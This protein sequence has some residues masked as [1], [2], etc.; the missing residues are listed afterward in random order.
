LP[1]ALAVLHE[2]LG[3]S[4]GPGQKLTLLEDFDRVLGLDF[5]DHAEQLSRVSEREQ[6]LLEE[7]AI[8][9]STRDWARSDELRSQLSAEG[10]EVKDTPSGQRWARTDLGVSRTDD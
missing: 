9:R 4:L 5:I 7:R 2:A 1:A 6:M 3:A 8:A 10:L